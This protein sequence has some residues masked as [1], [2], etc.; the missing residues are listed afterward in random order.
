MADRC[1]DT[2]KNIPDRVKEIVLKYGQFNHRF[3]YK[4]HTLSVNLVIT[5]A[6]IISSILALPFYIFLDANRSSIE[7]F[8]YKVYGK[9]VKWLEKTRYAKFLPWIVVVV[10]YQIEEAKKTAIEAFE[11]ERRE[12]IDI[13]SFC[14]LADIIDFKRIR[15]GRYV[16]SGPQLCTILED[17]RYFYTSDRFRRRGHDESVKNYVT[18][19]LQ[20]FS[21][22]VIRGIERYHSVRDI[23]ETTHKRPLTSLFGGLDSKPALQIK[24]DADRPYVP[25]GQTPPSSSNP[26]RG[27][28]SR[29]TRIRRRRK[30]RR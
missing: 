28:R 1:L 22:N 26:S 11:L 8:D 4:G 6:E 20:K 16:I 17:G 23:P 15:V 30:N 27:Y 13:A 14:G 21:E 24:T 3:K 12:S 25:S 9:F 2:I 29:R 10:D 19:F 5:M 18:A 7:T